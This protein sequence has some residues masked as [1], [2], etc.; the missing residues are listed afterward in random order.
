M[1]VLGLTDSS[2]NTKLCVSTS[3]ASQLPANACNACL[4]S[5]NYCV[6]YDQQCYH[7]KDQILEIH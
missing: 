5:I 7:I 3:S 4:S 1:Y 6:W 2:K